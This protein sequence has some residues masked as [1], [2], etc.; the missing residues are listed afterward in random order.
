VVGLE[1]PPTYE[2]LKSMKYLQA[3]CSI[4]SITQIKIFVTSD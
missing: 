4:T 1:E 2:D 3:S